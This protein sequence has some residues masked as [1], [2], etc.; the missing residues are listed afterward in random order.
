MLDGRATSSR[1]LHAL[2]GRWPGVTVNVGVIQAGT[3]PNVV[4]ERASL[5]VDVRATDAGGPGRRPR[6]RSATLAATTEP[7]PTRRSRSTAMARWSADGEARAVRAARRPRRGARRRGSGSRSRTPRPAARP[8]RTRRPGWACR[9]S[10]GSARSAAT[11]TRRRSTSRSPRSCRGPRCFAGAAP[12]G[13][14]ATRRSPLARRAGVGVTRAAADLV[15]RAVGGVGFGYSRA[16]VVGD[17]ATSRA[18]PMPGP[19]GRSL[20]PGDAGAQ[21]RAVVGDHRAGARRGGFE[22][23]RRRPD[24]DVRR[25]DRRRARR[26]GGPRRGLRRH[27]AGVDARPGRRP[28]RSVAARRGRGRR[29]PAE[30]ERRGQSRPAQPADDRDRDRGRRGRGSR[31]RR[32]ATIAMQAPTASHSQPDVERRAPRRSDDHHVDRG[33]GREHGRPD[34]LEVVE[35]RPGQPVDRRAP[36][37]RAP[38]DG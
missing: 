22:L 18:R 2:N 10:T 36:A 17:T 31:F 14:R 25:L 29:P 12:G 34:E 23:A 19:D 9:R 27:P 1:D 38:R 11:I 15:G 13:R 24:A 37:A 3:R 8:T 26:R 35:T 32:Q 33:K 5:E 28:H 7:C 6:R 21:A 16:I 4:A 20:H 30:P